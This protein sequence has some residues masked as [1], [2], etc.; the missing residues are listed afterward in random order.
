LEN[1]TWGTD[2]SSALVEIKNQIAKRFYKGPF[3]NIK[4]NE[5]KIMVSQAAENIYR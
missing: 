4:S 5:E 2:K 3:N 1:V